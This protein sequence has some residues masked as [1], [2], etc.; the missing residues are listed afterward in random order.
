MSACLRIWGASRGW[1]CQDNL[2]S[3]VRRPCRYDPDANPTYQEMAAHYG[4]GVLPARSGKPRD[5]AKAEAGVLIVERW[6]LA[7]LRN[8][9]FFSLSEL[10]REIRR[11]C[12]ELNDRPFQKLAGTRRSTAWCGSVSRSG[13]PPPPW[14]SSMT[15]NGWPC[16]GG[17]VTLGGPPPI[18]SIAPKRIG[19]TWPI[20]RHA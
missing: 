4:V 1:W 14:R 3:G 10:N 20:P 9:T 8:H 13:S 17:V 5:K 19:N 11:L 6:I 7:R 15:G 16:I 18:P 2:R 12:S